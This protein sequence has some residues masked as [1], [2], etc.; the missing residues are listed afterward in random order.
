MG[1]YVTVDIQGLEKLEQNLNEE[2]TK[3]FIEQCTKDIAARLLAKV[4]KI[5]PTGKYPKSTGKKGGTLK[6]GWTSEKSVSSMK[7]YVEGL[8]IERTGDSFTI[9]IINPV[10]YASYV[11]YGHRVKKKN[12]YGVAK[13]KKMLKVSMEQLEK[14]TPAALEKKVQRWLEECF[15]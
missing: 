1:K 2:R 8:S 5:T 14:E 7:S 6:R 9:Q 12:G 3:M 15:K 4:Y 13:G 10:E 11:E